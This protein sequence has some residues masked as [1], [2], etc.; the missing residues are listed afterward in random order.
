MQ[1]A[2][3]DARYSRAIRSNLRRC[4]RR[5]LKCQGPVSRPSEP[6]RRRDEELGFARRARVRASAPPADDTDTASALLKCA[7]YITYAPVARGTNS[8]AFVGKLIIE[9]RA[10]SLAK[11]AVPL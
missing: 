11:R 10:A 5:R 2:P 4:L 1:R 7:T 3:Q 8:P 6:R 9:L